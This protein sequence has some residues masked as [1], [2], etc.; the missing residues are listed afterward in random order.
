[1][2]HDEDCQK[3]RHK[4]YIQDVSSVSWRKLMLKV[5]EI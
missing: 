1:M 3:W 2:L 5:Y 4:H